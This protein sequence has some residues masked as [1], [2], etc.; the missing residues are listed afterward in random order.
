MS[1]SLNLRTSFFDD[2]NL[3]VTFE[4]QTPNKTHQK[5]L[6]SLPILSNMLSFRISPGSA[7]QQG[8][9]ALHANTLVHYKVTFF[10]I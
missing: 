7:L 2:K 8:F 6:N 10:E 9:F 3:N 4:F 1:T 5:D